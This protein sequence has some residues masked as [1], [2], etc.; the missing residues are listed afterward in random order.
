MS[1]LRRAAWAQVPDRSTGYSAP[2][3]PTSLR[4]PASSKTDSDAF[5]DLLDD[6]RTVSQARRDLANESATSRKAEELANRANMQDMRERLQRVQSQTDVDISDEEAGR[7]RAVLARE[8]EA[9]R[10]HE[11]AELRARVR[12]ER[13]RLKS[14][15]AVTDDDLMDEAAGRARL[16]LAARSAER[17]SAEAQRLAR[18]NAALRE[19]VRR[20]KTSK[21]DVDAYDDVIDE[22]SGRTAGEVRQELR[23]AAQMRRAAMARSLA[24]TNLALRE[25]LEAVHPKSQEDAHSLRWGRLSRGNNRFAANHEL[26]F[27]TQAK[28]AARLK[29]REERE[30]R[31]RAREAAQRE[32]EIREQRRLAAEEEE[33][34]RELAELEAKVLEEALA[35]QEALARLHEGKP[36]KEKEK[37]RATSSKRED[38]LRKSLSMAVERARPHLARKGMPGFEDE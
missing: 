17:R 6:G 19:R 13:A 28:E 32:E 20:A 30:E 7:M 35:K 2:V 14:V 21:T 23:E 24:E 11:A 1:A 34:Q 38:K 3:V 37:A 29:R 18:D 4:Q 16:E 5:D 26:A 8:S 25:R 27:G 9:R 22:E 15:Q 33:R 10:E 12:D 31:E 36:S